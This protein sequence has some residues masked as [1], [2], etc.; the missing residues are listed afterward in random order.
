MKDVAA[1]LA[2]TTIIGYGTFHTLDKEQVTSAVFTIC[3]G[4]GGL[5]ALMTMGNDLFRNGF[6][7]PFVEYEIFPVEFIFKT[8]FFDCIGIM[9][10]AALQVKYFL[11]SAMQQVGAGFFATDTPRTIHDHRLV[12]MVFQQFHSLRKLIAERVTG[13]FHGPV[14]MTHFKFIMIAHI[15]DEGV[16]I[17]G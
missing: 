4:I 7:Q 2:A 6:P 11:E 10:N 16:R 5:T 12:F 8:I 15:H 17:C 1:G 13:N 14:K 9:N 3:M